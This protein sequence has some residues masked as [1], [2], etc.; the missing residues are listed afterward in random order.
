MVCGSIAVCGASGFNAVIDFASTEP[1][2]FW[3]GGQHLDIFPVCLNVSELS[4][5]AA[6][7]EQEALV[8]KNE[9]GDF[10]A[11]D[12][13]RDAFSS[14]SSRFWHMLTITSNM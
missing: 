1:N 12:W 13:A 14:C 2:S 8:F 3:I 7:S 9:G 5:T 10:G 11:H 6:L 4:Y